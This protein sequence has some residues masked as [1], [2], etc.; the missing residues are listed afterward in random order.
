MQLQ[1]ARDNFFRLANDL[2]Q[3][4][5]TKKSDQSN[6]PSFKSVMSEYCDEVQEWNIAVTTSSP[7]YQPF[8]A[9]FYIDFLG[10]TT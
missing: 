1:T 2:Q 8:Y 10:N 5:P 3:D 9:S 4:Q 6:V 7:L